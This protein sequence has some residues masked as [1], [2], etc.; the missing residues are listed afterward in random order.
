MSVNRLFALL[1]GA[2][3]MTGMSVAHAQPEAASGYQRKPEVRGTRLMVATA[4]PYASRAGF[5]I[6]EQGGSAVDA[7]IA[8]QL[9]LGLTEPQSSGIGGGAFLL[10]FDARK[11]AVTAWDG[12]E[13]APAAA[14][15]A[16]FNG[17]DGK[18]VPFFDAVVGGRSVGVPGVVRMLEAAH[19][20]HGR[21][22]WSALF[23]SAITLA[24]EGFEVSPRLNRLLG[25]ERHLKRDLAAARYFYDS[26]GQPWPIGHLLRNP[27][28][29]DTLRQ[30]AERGSLALHAGPIARD[31]VAA[32]REHPTNPGLLSEHDLAFYQPVAREA[33]CA[34]YKRYLVCG[35]PPPSSGGLAVAQILGIV[36]ARGGVRLAQPDGTP[37]PDGVHAFAEAGR[38]AFADR[39][40]FI[41]DPAFVAPPS[42]LLDPAY[43]RQRAA[44]IGER[45]MGRAVA[46]RPDQRPRAETSEA[47][48]EQPA[49]SH[50]SILDAAG[51]AV[52]M[53]TTI[54][55][56]FG[57]RLM[58]RGFL[59]NNQ[60][61]DFSFSPQENGAPVAN[62][63]QPGTRPRSS[64]APSLVFEQP[65]YGTHAG[66]RRT[67]AASHAS[68][69]ATAPTQSATHAATSTSSERFGP[70]VMSLGSPGGSQ[71]IGYVARTLIATL[72]D[73]LPLQ[74]AIDMPN[75]GSRNGP[76]ELEAGV[77]S[78]TLATALRAR[79]H[80][81]RSIDMT[82]GLQGIMRRCTAPG[83]CILTG[84]ADPRREGLVIAR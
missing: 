38:L 76:T 13:T 57:A 65:A 49:T 79:G 27:A 9:V 22:P 6:L 4:N 77:A 53:T 1:L 32:V 39:N 12:R 8:A 83:T 59:L 21:L 68:T 20:Q 11:R 75:L 67:P 66:R 5:A 28:Y 23:Q 47:S 2:L 52:S 63:V 17:P 71:I 73:G 26:A 54:E 81:V 58:V 18:P 24:Q 10:H 80:E 37:D 62:R 61:T 50:L 42:G 44:L 16:L 14:S 7:A 84:G 69:V 74:Q 46:G 19:A 3:L 25:T 30:I 33:L 41:A 70:L 56:Q 31:I 35:M 36:E 34:P 64:M 78:D 60:L 15:E 48:L 45:S 82:S 43:L 40:Q 55:D 51:N 72:G 29:A